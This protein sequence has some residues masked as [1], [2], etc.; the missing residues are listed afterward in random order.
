PS[1]QSIAVT[2]IRNAKPAAS[3]RCFSTATTSPMG[4]LTAGWSVLGRSVACG[5]VCL[6]AVRT[7]GI[8]RVEEKGRGTDPSVAL[9]GH[10]PFRGRLAFHL[11]LQLH[12]RI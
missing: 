10:E 3:R 11:R 1:A 12:Q 5:N 8:E 7:S 4:T 2:S 9:R 6:S